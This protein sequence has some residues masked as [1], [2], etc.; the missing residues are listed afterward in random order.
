MD[1]ESAGYW[2]VRLTSLL[3]RVES[4]RILSFLGGTVADD[5]AGDEVGSRGS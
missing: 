2:T 4:I 1:V 5:P 3:G